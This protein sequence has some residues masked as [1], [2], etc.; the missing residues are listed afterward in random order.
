MK[1]SELFHF[2]GLWHHAFLFK[3]QGGKTCDL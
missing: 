2:K 1:A 3:Q